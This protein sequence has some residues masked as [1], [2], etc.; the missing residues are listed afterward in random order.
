ML[1][2][3]F[4]CDDELKGR[5]HAILFGNYKLHHREDGYTYIKFHANEIVYFDKLDGETKFDYLDG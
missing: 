1:V 5:Y 3:D 2:R 4:V